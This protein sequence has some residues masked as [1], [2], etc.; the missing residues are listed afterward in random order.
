LRIEQIASASAGTSVGCF[1]CRLGHEDVGADFHT[2]HDPRLRVPALWPLRE[3][4]WHRLRDRCRAPAAGG[5]DGL[6]AVILEFDTHAES[7][8]APS[9]FTSFLPSFGQQRAR[10]LGLVRDRTE[11]AGG[12]D[13]ASR[14]ARVLSVLPEGAHVGQAGFMLGR[15]PERVRLNVDSLTVEG[16]SRLLGDLEWPGD[17][18]SLRSQVG[19]LAARCD[20]FQLAIDVGAPA[21]PRF[22]VECFIGSPSAGGHAWEELL[23]HLGALGLCTEPKARAVLAWPGLHGGTPDRPSALLAR[24]LRSPTYLCRIN[25]VKVVFDARGAIEAKAY[26]LFSAP[27]PRT[28]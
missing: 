26:L 12:A 20:G 8:V 3:D 18:A 6:H 13:V 2:F 21:E 16:V 25:H 1:E 7:G 10:V 14:V 15:T 17:L 11:T 22:G 4:A 23:C 5:A 24:F 28:S 27:A 9:V 19:V